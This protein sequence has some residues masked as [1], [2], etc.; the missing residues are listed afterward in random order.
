MNCS[1][2]LSLRKEDDQMISYL[3]SSA[4]EMQKIEF[5]IRFYIGFFPFRFFFFFF[6]FR[7]APKI[8]YGVEFHFFALIWWFP[9]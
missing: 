6:L 2:S 9:G 1:C 4:F 5:R 3:A 8:R 7:A